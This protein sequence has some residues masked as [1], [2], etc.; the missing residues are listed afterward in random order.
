MRRTILPHA[1]RQPGIGTIGVVG[2]VTSVLLVVA[3]WA[4]PS[5]ARRASEETVGLSTLMAFERPPPRYAEYRSVAVSRSSSV[6]G[7]RPALRSVK[8]RPRARVITWRE[9]IERPEWDRT[10]FVAEVNRVLTDPRGWGATGEVVFRH[11]TSGMPRMWVKLASP[12]R[13]D[14]LCAPTQTRGIWNCRAG[15]S[16]VVNSDRWFEGRS[17]WPGSIAD[18]RALIINHET[19]HVLGFGHRGCAGH[20]RFA[21][22]MQQQG[23]SLAGCRANP[24]PLP[25]EL[26]RL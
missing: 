3:L 11:I 16:V 24:W 9:W 17:T 4:V 23:V 8:A 5:T 25:G 10:A 26:A 18:Y 7:S 2:T 1:G 21:P 6:V 22:V 12:R 15:N 13:T 20:G 19:G 14:R